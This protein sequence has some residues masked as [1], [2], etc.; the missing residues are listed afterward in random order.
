MQVIV[1]DARD[2][3]VRDDYER[4][5]AQGLNAVGEA[6]GEEGEGEVGGGEESFC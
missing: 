1:V 4:K 5:V 2:V 6:D 3:R